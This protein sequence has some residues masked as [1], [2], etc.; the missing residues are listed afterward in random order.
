MA[1]DKA[2]S[3]DHA[4][5]EALGIEWREATRARMEGWHTP[6]GNE[7]LSRGRVP[8]FSEDLNLSFWAA[9]RA[10]LFDYED[11]SWR[12]LCKVQNRGSRVASW[13]IQ[14][15]HIGSGVFDWVTDRHP[16]PALA[17]CEAILKL[18]G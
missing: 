7:V 10:G 13:R 15:H 18:R 14:L 4:V 1:L 11:D 2:S 6:D 17:I 16:T 5:A 3:M 8:R 12:V 9:E